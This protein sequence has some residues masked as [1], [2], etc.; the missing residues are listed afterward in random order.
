MYVNETNRVVANRDIVIVPQAAFER[1]ELVITYHSS[2]L[3]RFVKSITPLN[4]NRRLSS[5]TTANIRAVL[6][7]DVRCRSLVSRYVR[8]ILAQAVFNAV[9]HKD[10]LIAAQRAA[11]ICRTLAVSREACSNKQINNNQKR[12][13]SCSRKSID[14]RMR[15]TAMHTRRATANNASN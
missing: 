12:N 11:F 7:F 13:R 15:P 5:T 2:S 9:L 1:F 3:S 4:A 8:N 6:C 10:L 14:A